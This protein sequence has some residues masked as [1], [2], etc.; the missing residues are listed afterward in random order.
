[1][2]TKEASDGGGP[3]ERLRA[4]GVEVRGVHVQNPNEAA[5]E[6]AVQEVFGDQTTNLVIMAMVV[7]AWISQYTQVSN[8]TC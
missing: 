3:E 7:L 4:V 8:C 2:P 1:M 6:A 5:R